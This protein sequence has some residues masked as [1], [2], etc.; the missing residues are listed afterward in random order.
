MQ[1][2][3]LLLVIGIIGATGWIYRE[4]LMNRVNPPP[5]PPLNTADLAPPDSTYRQSANADHHSAGIY[6]WKDKD[7]TVHF[8]NRDQAKDAQAVSLGRG[9]T[10]SLK[11]DSPEQD[12][13]P[14]GKTGAATGGKYV[15]PT[16]R[17]Q[18]TLHGVGQK[19]QAELDAAGYIPN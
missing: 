16:K 6:S 5:P 2:E 15:P 8:G 4:P 17:V 12:A 1:K 13:P 19:Q 10:V 18:E 11:D 7:G 14:A 3:T 9:N